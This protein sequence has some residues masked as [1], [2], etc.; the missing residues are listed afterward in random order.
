MGEPAVS[1]ATARSKAPR[2]AVAVA[3]AATVVPMLP[4]T[5]FTVDDAWVPVRYARSL[6]L[7]AGYRPSAGAPVS[8]GVTPLGFAHLLWP[9]AATSAAA[10]HVAARIAGVL[11]VLAAMGALGATIARLGGSRLRFAALLLVATSSP[12]AAWSLAGLETGLVTAAVALALVLRERGRGKSGALALGLAAAWRPELLPAAVVV[13]FSATAPE[14]DPARDEA[15]P[16]ARSLR[17]VAAVAPALA[18]ASIRAAAFGRAAPLSVHAKTPVLAMG[19]SYAGAAALLAG[20]VAIFAPRALR[21]GGGWTRAL[22]LAVVAHVAAMA[23]AGGDWMPLAR[24]A[25]PVVPIVVLVAARTLVDPPR[26]VFRALLPV[27]VAVGFQIFGFWRALPAVQSIERDRAALIREMKPVL[28]DA[29]TIAA[30][31]VGW[32]SVAAEHARVVDLAGITDPTVAAIPG[33]HTSKRLPRTFF[34]DRD[35]DTIVLLLGKD[36]ARADAA[37]P[38]RK[39]A[40]GTEAWTASIPEMRDAYEVAFTSAT[41]TRYVVLRRVHVPEVPAPPRQE[42]PGG[43]W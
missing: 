36:E 11:A 22:A 6:A 2:L 14:I 31:D 41:R 37:W 39:Y 35:V 1:T 17:V 43:M 20:Y 18:V 27:A 15:R 26:P 23:F 12:L 40:R 28:R 29:R 4:V 38:D 13:S 3:L 9:I 19:V 7:G 16:L 24:L 10:A 33:G 30:V 25:V 21:R 8:D 42:E 32:L 5:D 34:K